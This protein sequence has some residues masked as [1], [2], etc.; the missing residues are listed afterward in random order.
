ML[1]CPFGNIH[2]DDERGAAIKC[3]LCGGNPRCVEYCPT[4]AL[5]YQE[6]ENVAVVKQ[7]TLFVKIKER[8]LESRA[9]WEVAG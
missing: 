3:E 9:I 7:K 6:I 4:G 2:F 1:A 8:Y 5:S